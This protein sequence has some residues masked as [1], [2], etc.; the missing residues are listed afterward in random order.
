MKLTNAKL[1]FAEEKFEK[2]LTELLGIKAFS[3]LWP[4]PLPASP[5]CIEQLLSV[6]AEDKTRYAA[7]TNS[8][9]SRH[10]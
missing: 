10:W 9:K 6:V 1:R 3:T 4:L 8:L 5:M 2:V 7:D